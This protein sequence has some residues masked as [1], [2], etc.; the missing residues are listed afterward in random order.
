[1]P[2]TSTQ[3]FRHDDA[4]VDLF[5]NIHG[6]IMTHQVMVLLF[7]WNFILAP[8]HHDPA[9]PVFVGNALSLKVA[10]GVERIATA[11]SQALRDCDTL[12]TPSRQLSVEFGAGHSVVRAR[13]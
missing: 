10:Q 7:G 2:A 5:R 11:F 8:W 6:L 4:L 3:K 12:V 13:A 9:P 1:V